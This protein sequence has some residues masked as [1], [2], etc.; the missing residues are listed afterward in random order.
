MVG[1]QLKLSAQ[2]SINTSGADIQGSGG[3]ISY[4]VGQVAYKSNF[5]SNSSIAEGVQQ[6]F[7]ISIITNIEQ[8]K[9]ISLNCIV[10]PNP[11][12]DFLILKIENYSLNNLSYKI[13]DINGKLLLSNKIE[14]IEE[15]IAIANLPVASYLLKVFD[16]N[17]EI[18]IFK[19]IKN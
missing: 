11:T 9:D 15:S 6:P 3:N 13:F 2:Q 14:S 16:K 5:G 7:E 8:A 12:T 4:S 1:G 19:I 10:Y 17:K 18:K